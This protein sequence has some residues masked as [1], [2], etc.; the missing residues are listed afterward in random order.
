MAL[1]LE[2]VRKR[3]D[4]DEPDYDKLAAT[5]GPEAAPMLAALVEDEDS[6]VAS[7]AAYLLSM[8]PGPES[9]A[10]LEKAARSHDENVRVAAAA[11]FRNV[12]S[13]SSDTLR[14][15]LSDSD[16][17]VRKVAL[18]SVQKVGDRALRDEVQRLAGADQ[19]E[20]LRA[21]ARE[22]LKELDN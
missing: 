17:G 9:Q 8:I 3:I 16:P 15:L 6:A 20:G 10:G 7:K 5:L 13:R 4:V 11:G 19:E 21:V 14:G 18:Q 1:E 2:E 12:A 22:V